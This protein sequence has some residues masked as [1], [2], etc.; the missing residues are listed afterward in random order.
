[1]YLNWICNNNNA[2]FRLKEH[3]RCHI[4]PSPQQSCAAFLW[5]LCKFQNK[6]MSIAMDG[7][8]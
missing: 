4:A 5:F 7:L 3:F 2:A 1:M 6:T 8:M